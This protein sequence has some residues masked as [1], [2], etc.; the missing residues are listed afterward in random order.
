M[1]AWKLKIIYIYIYGS[2]QVSELA[3]A[4]WVL[5]FDLETTFF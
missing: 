1:Y 5:T 2:S 3:M 4:D